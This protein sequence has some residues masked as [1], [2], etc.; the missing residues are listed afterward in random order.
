[1]RDLGRDARRARAD[2][3]LVDHLARAE[4][5]RAAVD[6]PLAA[7]IL[8]PQRHLVRHVELQ[9]SQLA[10]I[11]GVGVA[12]L[13]GE[14]DRLRAAGDDQQRDEATEEAG[15]ARWVHGPGTAEGATV[16]HL[17]GA[18]AAGQPLRSGEGMV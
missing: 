1:V 15:E 9:A 12:K 17:R 6:P 16:F 18:R 5:Q 2:H 13:G 11:D 8:T 3:D 14:R 7:Q 10:V 4:S